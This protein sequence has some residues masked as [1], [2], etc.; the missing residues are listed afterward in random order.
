MRSSHA[1]ASPPAS[2]KR[3]NLFVLAFKHFP[4]KFA[5]VT[6]SLS[7]LSAPL[8]YDRFVRDGIE[9]VFERILLTGCVVVLFPLLALY[10][11]M[12]ARSARIRHRLERDE[13]IR[14]TSMSQEMDV[15]RA[16]EV[17]DEQEVLALEHRVQEGV[18]ASDVKNKIEDMRWESLNERLGVQEQ[19]EQLR[20]DESA[21]RHAAQEVTDTKASDVRRRSD[22]LNETRW[23]ELFGRLN[24]IEEEHRK[25]RER[26]AARP[27]TDTRSSEIPTEEELK[28]QY[29]TLYQRYIKHSPGKHDSGTIDEISTSIPESW[30]KDQPEIASNP[31]LFVWLRQH[32][33][34][35]LPIY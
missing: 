18:T 8:L 27:K 23:A 35:H 5:I 9:S 19:G 20:T 13:D 33:E 16:Q 15:L 24:A 31:N 12:L 17:K 3:H 2:G 26:R 25:E 11:V 1:V 34:R 7:F 10:L 14:M 22:A 29:L 28:H 21:A 6:V 4:E 32:N 30:L